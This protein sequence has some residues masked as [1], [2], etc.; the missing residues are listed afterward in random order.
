MNREEREDREG[1]DSHL[2]T[3]ARFALL[4]VYRILQA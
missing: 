3:L 4:A 1:P 2:P